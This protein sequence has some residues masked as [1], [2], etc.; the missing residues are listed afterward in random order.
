MVPVSDVTLLSI[1]F[2]LALTVFLVVMTN[3]LLLIGAGLFSK[4]VWD[5]QEN[6]FNH[7]CAPSFVNSLF[8]ETDIQAALVQM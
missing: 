5:F 8:L 3:F 1:R 6:A 4:A 7:L 2:F